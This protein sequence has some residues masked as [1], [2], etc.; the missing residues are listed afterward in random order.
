M[1]IS[2][3]S[4][5]E[6]PLT[7]QKCHSSNED[8]LFAVEYEKDRPKPALVCVA[9]FVR[10]AKNKRLAALRGLVEWPFANQG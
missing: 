10:T 8:L 2:Y 9:C 6:G 5:K 4:V 3:K 7:C 1:P